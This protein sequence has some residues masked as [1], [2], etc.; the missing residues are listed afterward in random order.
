MLMEHDGELNFATN[1]WTS[2]NHYAFCAFG[3]QFHHEGQHMRLL[4]DI[5]EVLMLHSGENLAK[6]FKVLL[7]EFKIADKLLAII[8]DNATSNDAI[9]NALKDSIVDFPGED[10]QSI[11]RPFDIDKKELEVTLDEAEKLLQELAEGLDVEDTVQ[12]DS[13]VDT[14]EN[15]DDNIEGWQ[16]EAGRLSEKE[17]CEAVYSVKMV[18]VKLRKLSFS[19]IYSTTHLLPAW[20]ALLSE[21]KLAIRH[22]PHDVKIWWN[23]TF[24]MLTFT[25]EYRTAIDWFTSDCSLRKY[26]LDP[27]EWKIVEQLCEVLHI[28]YDATE[29]FSCNCASIVDVIPVMDDIDEFLTTAALNEGKYLDCIHAAIKLGKK[30]LNQYYS[31]TDC[32]KTYCIAIILHLSYKL[33]YFTKLKWEDEWIEDAEALL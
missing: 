19:I 17:L 26:E 16:D 30:T 32:S 25:L 12:E 2:P 15:H 24:T 5:V 11:L 21:L 3:V 9:I 28:F 6:A 1:C 27:Y 23:S 14:A 29:F 4:L 22:M 7:R 13:E 33:K 20:E 31:K 8:A 10:Y 18:L